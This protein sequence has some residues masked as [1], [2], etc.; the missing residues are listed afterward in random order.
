MNFVAAIDARAGLQL[1]RLRRRGTEDQQGCTDPNGFH[2]QPRLTNASHCG[3]SGWLYAIER[4]G[5]T[6]V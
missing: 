1:L 6:A 5:A 3:S 2:L 4:R